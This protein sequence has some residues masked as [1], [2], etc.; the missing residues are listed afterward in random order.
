M[1]HSILGIYDST[2]RKL[3]F[4]EINIVK[5]AH[6][7]SNTKQPSYRIIVDNEIIK[8]ESTLLATYKCENCG[9]TIGPYRINNYIRRLKNDVHKCVKCREDDKKRSEQSKFMVTYNG[10]PKPREKTKTL[11][12]KIELSCDSFDKESDDFKQS[13]WSKHYNLSQFNK[14]SKQIVKIGDTEYDPFWQYVPI[15]LINNREKYFPRLFDNINNV[16]L[17]INNVH[18]KC[19]KCGEMSKSKCISGTRNKC[20]F[21]CKYCYLVTDTF[22]I[23]KFTST[24]GFCVNYQ[25]NLELNF[26]KWCDENNIFIANG[27]KIKYCFDNVNRTYVVDFLVNKSILVELKDWHIWHKKQ[28]ESGKWAAKEIAAIKYCKNN[29]LE[30]KLLFPND[31]DEFKNELLRYSLIHGESR[32]SRV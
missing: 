22:K 12:E 17:P 7:Y 23:K 9:S 20:R 30:F 14:Y 31:M 1:E 5:I 19:L 24:K 25:S 21:L 4:R 28:I 15:F 3:N 16:M 27:P 29:N 13:Y 10:K 26:V 18:F 6:K 2:G 32:G 8:K 11:Q